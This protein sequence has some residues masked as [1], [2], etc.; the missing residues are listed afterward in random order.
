[1]GVDTL[2]LRITMTHDVSLQMFL[3]NQHNASGSMLVIFHKSE[4]AWRYTQKC[5]TV[6]FQEH[7]TSN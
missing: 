6:N 3:P 4:E 1:M 2:R 7:M 5:Y